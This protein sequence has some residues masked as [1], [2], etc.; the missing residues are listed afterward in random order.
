MTDAEVLRKVVIKATDFN[1]SEFAI[2]VLDYQ[3]SYG[4]DLDT[5]INY[6][7]TD[8]T[9]IIMLFDYSFAKALWGEQFVEFEVPVFSEKGQTYAEHK[10]CKQ[11]AWK[12]YLQRMVLHK[13]RIDY[14]RRFIE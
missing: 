7:V 14:L 3:P 9:Y 8:H 5:F 4:C 6:I 2:E 11:I 12:H 13:K 1:W 10:T